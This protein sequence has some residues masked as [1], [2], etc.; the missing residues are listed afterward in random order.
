MKATTKQSAPVAAVK[1]VKGKLAAP[2]ANELATLLQAANKD[3]AKEQA[4]KQKV[5]DKLCAD[6]AVLTLHGL[7]VKMVNS[8]AACDK[9]Q[10]A[11][12][13]AFKTYCLAALP[14]I[15][16]SAAH[17][18]AIVDIHKTF[19]D[20]R[21]SAAIQR[22]TMLNN[23]R[24]IA[25][26]KVATRDTA[27]QPAQGLQCVLDALEAVSSM[28]A[29]KSALVTLKAVKHAS[30]GVAKVEPKAGTAKPQ[31]VKVA[32]V[33]AE[34]VQ[35]PGTRAEAIK[36]ACRMLEFIAREFLTVSANSAEIAQC[37]SVVKALR[38]VA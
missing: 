31:G 19:G 13:T 16:K 5:D 11:V 23:M 1:L 12:Y 4:A 34:D 29:I 2:D 20:A 3:Y 15:G 37:D 6:A 27:A 21:K 9:A 35:I 38:K 32:P 26:G 14:L 7:A 33:K 8:E 22:I 36:A 30:A 10:N 24:T 17:S 28:P 18:A 25:Y